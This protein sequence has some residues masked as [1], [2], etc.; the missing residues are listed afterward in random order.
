MPRFAWAAALLALPALAG[1]W[2]VTEDGHVSRVGSGENAGATLRHEAVVR[3]LREVAQVGAAELRFTPRDA[4]G[5]ALR[6]VQ[7]VVTDAASG[8]PLQALALGC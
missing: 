1:Y 8:L 5:A 7:F 3:E 4:A 6:K 2:A